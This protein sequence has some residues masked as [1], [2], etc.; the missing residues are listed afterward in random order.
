MRVWEADGLRQD[1]DWIAMVSTGQCS[2]KIWD[3]IRRSIRG[4]SDS[5]DAEERDRMETQ[6]HALALVIDAQRMRRETEA[7]IRQGY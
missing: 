3:K 7:K 4:I 1:S 6:F 2:L 5:L